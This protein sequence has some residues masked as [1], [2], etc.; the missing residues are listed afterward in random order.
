MLALT[1]LLHFLKLRSTASDLSGT[2]L[3]LNQS[4]NPLRRTV[5]LPRPLPVDFTDKFI[6]SFAEPVN[7]DTL[8]SDKAATGWLVWG[9]SVKFYGVP[10]ERESTFDWD[11]TSR[12]TLEQ[13]RDI[14]VQAGWWET[15]IQH[16]AME[17]TIDV[18]FFLRSCIEP[19]TDKLPMCSTSL[20]TFACSSSPSSKSSRTRRSNG[21]S[22]L[23]TPSSPTRR[24]DT[25]SEQRES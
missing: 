12:E 6:E 24:I 18:R 15:F 25:S 7:K 19:R 2:S 9:D 3:L 14:I 13:L 4:K 21:S 8:L 1:K 10:D 22:P 16:L 11:E 17:K 23:S 5:V 20:P